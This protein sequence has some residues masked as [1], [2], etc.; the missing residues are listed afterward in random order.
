LYIATTRATTGDDT[1]DYGATT[2]SKGAQG[3]RAL[4]V[5]GSLSVAWPWGRA[6]RADPDPTEPGRPAPLGERVGCSAGASLTATTDAR[7]QAADRWRRPDVLRVARTRRSSRLATVAKLS[8][9]GCGLRRPSLGA[10]AAVAR[11]WS[12]P[13]YQSRTSTVA[14]SSSCPPAACY[15]ALVSACTASRGGGGR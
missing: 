10:P 7:A 14:L 9:V 15:T 2:D 5:A 1:R 6:G 12:G 13:P 3:L 4:S 11:C 8:G